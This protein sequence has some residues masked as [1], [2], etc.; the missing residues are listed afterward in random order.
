MLSPFVKTLSSTIILFFLVTAAFAGDKLNVVTT[1]PDFADIA[2]Q[3]G[4]DKIEAFAIAKGYQDPHFVDPKPSYIIKLQKADMFVHAGL[5]LE[6]GWV[7]PLLEGARNAKIL[8]GAQGNVDASKGVPLLEIPSGDPAQ[9]RAQGDIHVFGN[10]HYWLDPGRGKRIA[11][12][13]FDGLARLRPQDEAYFKNNLETFN[14]KIEA[15]IAA[16]EALIRPFNGAKIVAFH[17]SW[18]YFDE[19]FDF[20]VIAFVEPK[21]GIPPSPKHLAE[22]INKMNQTGAKVIIIEPYY[23]KKACELVASKTGAQVV[24]LATAVDGVAA[25]K[26]YFDVFDYNLKKLAAAFQATGATGSNKSR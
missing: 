13:I 15:Q 21:P 19:R 8:P 25:A 7:P 6:I 14:K 24:E 3:I 12:N 9:L 4:G 11:Q 10:P 16:W 5:D 2:Q 1:L 20:A 26:S 22:V 17:N 23:S 18:P